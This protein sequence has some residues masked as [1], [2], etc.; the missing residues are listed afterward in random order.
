MHERHLDPTDDVVTDEG[1]PLTVAVGPGDTTCGVV[2]LHEIWGL[3][4][5]VIGLVTRFAADGYVVA[6]PHL[7][8]RTGSA[9]VE[10]STYRLARRAHNTLDVGSIRSDLVSAIEWCRASGAEKVGVVGFSMGGTIALWAAAELD[11]DAAVTFYGGGITSERWPGL[12]SGTEAAR[13]LKAPWLGIYG[14]RDRSTP[15]RDL[16]AMRA[17]LPPDISA[18]VMV[19]PDAGHGFALDPESSSYRAGPAQEAFEVMDGF[20]GEHLR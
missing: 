2:I 8:H 19:Y 5:A 13:N 3:T 16:E 18:K 10:D 7:Y 14:G 11:I 12:L 9:L 6:A 15:P 4:D 17:V 20:L 1:L